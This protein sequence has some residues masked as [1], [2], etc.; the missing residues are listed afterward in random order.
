MAMAGLRGLQP[1]WGREEREGRPCN[2]T[3]SWPLLHPCLVPH[4]LL[5]ETRVWE[6]GNVYFRGDGASS[7]SRSC[8]NQES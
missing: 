2:G 1:G 6:V 5:V 3:P 7:Y 4:V 8:L